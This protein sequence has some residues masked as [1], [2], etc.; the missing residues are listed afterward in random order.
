MR[1]N[2]SDEGYEEDFV[3][4][5][6]DSEYLAPC[7]MMDDVGLDD[8]ELVRISTK[9]LNRHLKRRNIDKN[10]Q[11]EIK[12]RRRTLKNRGYAASCRVKRDEEE[13]TI[14]AEIEIL[15]QEIPVKVHER[16]A[17][18]SLNDSLRRK[19]RRYGLSDAEIDELKK[20]RHYLIERD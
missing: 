9:D 8:I 4:H 7:N 11:K 18:N 16:N 3:D 20:G 15:E 13:E 14:K 17:A 6:F 5:D 12:A 10:R 1:N 2:N 19:L